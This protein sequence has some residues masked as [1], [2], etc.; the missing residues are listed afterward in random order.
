MVDCIAKKVQNRGK[1]MPPE[2][3]G[4]YLRECRLRGQPSQFAAQNTRLPNQMGRIRAASSGPK[5]QQRRV[6]VTQRACPEKDTGTA[7]RIVVSKPILPSHSQTAHTSSP[8]P[9]VLRRLP[10]LDICTC[11]IIVTPLRKMRLF[12]RVKV[13]SKV[14]KRR[15]KV[16]RLSAMI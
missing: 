7:C 3:R 2:P 12:A 6:Q 14:V 8:S 15:L 10:L 9:T 4:P 1:G 5:W 16:G 13:D 11:P